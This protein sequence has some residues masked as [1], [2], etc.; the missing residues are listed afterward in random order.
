[1]QV[2]S[3]S[4]ALATVTLVALPS[5]VACT[6]ASGS[7]VATVHLG[8][9][10]NLTQA[11]AVLAVESGT[12][13]DALG[14]DAELRPVAFGA[15][16]DAAIALF[17]GA[18]D[19]AFLGPSPT[20]NAFARSDGGAVRIVAGATSGGASLV[21]KPEI[22]EPAD[23]RGATIASPQLGN[24]QDVALRAWLRDQGLGTDTAG[25]GDV[26]IRPQ[27]NADAL[28]GFLDGTI[29]GAWAP[30]P[31]ATR[32]RL[33]GDGVVLVDE[34]D[35]WPRG[36]FVTTHL[37]ARTEFLE[38]HPDLVRKVIEGLVDAI[39]EI[40]RDPERARRAVN[41]GLEK[42]TTKRLP[43]E[44]LDAAW[45]QLTFTWDP[46]APSLGAARDHAVSVGLLEPTDLD[47]IYDLSLLNAVLAE[48]G[49][50]GVD[51]S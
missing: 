25:G 17:S 43:A 3:R 40:D 23:L 1:M 31:W 14:P 24:T 36:R 46:I 26:S 41:D 18:I 2:R 19:L 49:R 13:Q 30:E 12:F 15:G 7:G 38:E 44:T 5:L 35:L 33:E 29:E 20:I 10:A 42:M 28:A 37:V 39:D 8:Y 9:S 50:R 22:D 51:D 11:P 48:R 47:G 45:G 4:L 21:V 34:R 6:D 32:L 27:S 16:P